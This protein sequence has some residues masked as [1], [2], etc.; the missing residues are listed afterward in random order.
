LQIVFIIQARTVDPVV[1]TS[2]LI[3]A[4]TAG[5]TAASVTYDFDTDPKR[6]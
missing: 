3:S 2:L 5:Y 4:L 1:A 6:R